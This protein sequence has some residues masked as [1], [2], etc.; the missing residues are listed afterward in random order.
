[1]SV[2]TT[3]WN[4][5]QPSITDY[6][7]WA[8]FENSLKEFKD[9]KLVD[10]VEFVSN[11]LSVPK[12][13]YYS[14]VIK[15]WIKAE[16]PTPKLRTWEDFASE[17]FQ[18]KI[19]T[20]N[21]ILDAKQWFM[22]GVKYSKDQQYFQKKWSNASDL[23]SHTPVTQPSTSTDSLSSLFASTEWEKLQNSI[24]SISNNKLDYNFL[25]TGINLAHNPFLNFSDG[26]KEATCTQA[27]SKAKYGQSEQ[28]F[29]DL[30]NPYIPWN[31]KWDNL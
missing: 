2:N 11:I 5:T 15:A 4:T 26:T 12:N 16:V 3:Y 10:T 24:N 7:I 27:E 31:P 18:R 17:Y 29:K 25:A 28:K 22:E 19:E 20:S 21:E 6:P 1:M 13:S 23:N 9:G 8:I 30:T 14:K